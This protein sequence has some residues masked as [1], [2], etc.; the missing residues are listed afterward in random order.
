[1]SI[2]K[3]YIYINNKNLLVTIIKV[4]HYVQ[5]QNKTKKSNVNRMEASMVFSFRLRRATAVPWTL[6]AKN[7]PESGGRGDFVIINNVFKHEIF[8]NSSEF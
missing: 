1:M 2:Q 4:Q 6:H 8:L 5:K 3:K 7:D